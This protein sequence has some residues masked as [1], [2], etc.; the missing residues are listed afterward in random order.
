M[1]T[2]GWYGKLPSLGDFASRRLPQPFLSAWDNWLQHAIAQ[3]REQLGARWLDAYLSSHIWRF[4][5]AP[6]SLLPGLWAGVLLPSVDRVGRYFP[7]T[8]CAEFGSLQGIDSAVLEA[9]FSSLETAARIGLD[10]SAGPERLDAALGAAPDLIAGHENGAASILGKALRQPHPLTHFETTNTSLA[11]LLQST[12]T[13]L[14]EACFAG[15]S[16]WACNT[17]TAMLGGFV[18]EGM[19]QPAVFAR[20]LEYTPGASA[21]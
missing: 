3:S 11:T 9:W 13:A 2:P 14:F 6:G 7:L 17:P 1:N 12:Q 15:H 19:P 21:L 5:L 20:M 4:I 18:C 10:A 16:L 8:L